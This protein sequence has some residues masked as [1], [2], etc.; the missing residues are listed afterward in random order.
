L[1]Y[2]NPFFSP[3]HQLSQVFDTYQQAKAAARKRTEFL[4]VPPDEDGAVGT[5]AASDGDLIGAFSGALGLTSVGFR[6]GP[7]G[8]PAALDGIDL[9]IA[10][11]E[12]IALVGATGAGKSTVVKLVARFYDPTAG[13][14]DADGTDLRRLPLNAYRRHLGFVPQESH[15]FSGTVAENIAY[16]R[17]EAT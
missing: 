14:V 17:P 3:L 6:Y 10:A 13:A 11:G 2:L 9:L 7:E 1:L 16:G 12:T 4:A 5:R 15:L 8:T